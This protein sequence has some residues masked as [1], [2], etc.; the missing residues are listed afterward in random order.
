MTAVPALVGMLTEP[1]D[2]ELSRGRIDPIGWD[3]ARQTANALGDVAPGTPRAG[4]VVG[5]L[6]EV[7]RAR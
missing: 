4:D 6:V 7:F 5:A 3:L 2:P 1:A